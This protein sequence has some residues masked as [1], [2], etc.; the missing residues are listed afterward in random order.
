MKNDTKLKESSD[1]NRWTKSCNKSHYNRSSSSSSDL[2]GSPSKISILRVLLIVSI[3]SAGLLSGGF[4]YYFIRKYQHKLYEQEFN[5]LIE[6]NYKLMKQSLFVKS[7]INR[8][9][10]TIFGRACPTLNHWPSCV[11]SSKEFIDRTDSLVSV[12]Q[13]TQF[14]ITPI[15]KPENKEE[16]ENFAKNYYKNDG[17]Y[18][19]GA[20][21]SSFGTE[22]Y[23]YDSNFNRVPTSNHS[24]FGH[25]DIFLPVLQVSNIPFGVTSLLFDTHS[26]PAIGR[27]G[28]NILDCVNHMVQ[29]KG[30]NISSN[31]DRVEI[32]KSCSFMTDFIPTFGL[33]SSVIGTPI[34]PINDTDPTNLVVVGI[35][36]SLFSWS[37]ILS[38][39]SRVDS[40]FFCVIESSTNIVKLYYEVNNGIVTDYQF[41]EYSK[42]SIDDF[43]N[44]FKKSYV[45]NS[46]NKNETIYTITYYSTNE[47]P[48]KYLAI[49]ACCCC[50]GITIIISVIFFC[51][52]ILIKRKAVEAN[53]LL[54]SKRIFVRF[55]SH[56]I[57]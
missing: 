40:E 36:G 35:S 57:R 53:V 44:H 54:D 14:A 31:V 26:D 20:G 46:N 23:S 48:S 52:N 34:F 10:A 15:V 50:I 41:P 9:I 11:L 3:T 49:L 55:L 51:F 33:K 2:G 38:S 27:T 56:E 37:S 7:E 30:L 47:A 18:P 29:E 24:K 6:D 12:S 39:T 5:N 21:I 32:Q 42:K 43:N 19:S 22:I 13:I 45:L 8:Q 1:T 17:G 25:Y 28:E 16:F 4:S